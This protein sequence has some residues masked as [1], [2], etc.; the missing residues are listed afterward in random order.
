M[1]MAVK[2]AGLVLSQIG[3]HKSR[4][5]VGQ[6]RAKEHDLGKLAVDD[7]FDF[8]PIDLNFSSRRVLDRDKDLGRCQ[9]PA[10]PHHEIADGSSTAGKSVF[11]DQ[12]FVN[13]NGGVSLFSVPRLVFKKP[14]PNDGDKWIELGSGFGGS[15][16][17]GLRRRTFEGFCDGFT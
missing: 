12:A 14:L 10:Q 3:T 4:F 5:A 17:V 1:H 15:E 16:L 8:A 6:S 7:D 13:T 11:I 9:F 2:E